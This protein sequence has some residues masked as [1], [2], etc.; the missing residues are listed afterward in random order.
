MLPATKVRVLPQ[1]LCSV[2]KWTSTKAAAAATAGAHFMQVDDKEG[3]NSYYYYDADEDSDDDDD[4]DGARVALM[5]AKLVSDGFFKREG[6]RPKVSA[7]C[8]ATFANI[9]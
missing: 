9:Q 4:D 2:L 8:W 7:V 1:L 6:K 3:P 5:I